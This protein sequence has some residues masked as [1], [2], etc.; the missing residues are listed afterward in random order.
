MKKEELKLKPSAVVPLDST[1]P[2]KSVGVDS[3]MPEECRLLDI[4]RTKVIDGKE[5]VFPLVVTVTNKG[6]V[7]YYSKK[8]NKIFELYICTHNGPRKRRE[9]P[10]STSWYQAVILKRRYNNKNHYLHYYVHRLVALA[11]PDICGPMLEG[12]QV[13]HINGIRDDNRAENLRCI[14]AYENM[15]NAAQRH[16]MEKYYKD[17]EW[18]KKISESVQEGKRRAKELRQKKALENIFN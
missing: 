4:S 10:H 8:F 7:F 2:E 18:R 12:Y 6:R 11:F 16:K 14:P 5:V 15:H 1:M 9:R 3:K 17:P 13:D